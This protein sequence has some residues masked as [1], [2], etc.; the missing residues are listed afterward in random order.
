MDNL[1]ELHEIPNRLCKVGVRPLLR[2]P[3]RILFLILGILNVILAV[4]GAILPGMP[5]TVFLI[6]AS[7]CFARSCPWLEE[8]L[9]RMKVFAPYI[10]FINPAVPV[11]RAARIRALTCMWSFIA[12]AGTLFLVRGTGSW[13]CPT[14]VVLLGFIGTGCILRYRR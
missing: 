14:G 8:R 10:G 2:S 6:A 12:I 4:I 3:L 7:Y 5:T 9:L 1:G 11:T 13:W